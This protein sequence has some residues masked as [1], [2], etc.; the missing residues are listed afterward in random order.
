MMGQQ[1]PGTTS[2]EDAAAGL[3]GQAV[4]GAQQG[5][6]SFLT[7]EFG[8]PR[9]DDAELGTYHLWIYQCSWRIEHG[10]ELGAGDGDSDEWIAA[11]LARLN[12]EPITAI[13]IPRPS[14]SAIFEF[15]RSRLITFGIYTDATEEDAEQWLLYRPD[16]L[17]LAV[18]PGSTWLLIPL[19]Q[20]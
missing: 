16:D 18:G 13:S 2:P 20:P 3:I 1:M 10:S 7:L 9:P 17:L 6:G 19:D 12:G 11:A 4:W 5:Y 15:G 14:L 8:E